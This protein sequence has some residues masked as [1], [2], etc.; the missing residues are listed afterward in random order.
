MKFSESI[1]VV[2]DDQS[3]DLVSL[4]KERGTVLLSGFQHQELPET[5]RSVEAETARSK[6]SGAPD[7]SSEPDDIFGL[8]TSPDTTEPIN[9]S[10]VE[11]ELNLDLSDDE[12]ELDLDG[13]I[14][15]EAGQP[16]RNEPLLFE[17]IRSMSEA[18]KIRTGFTIR[19]GVTHFQ[20]FTDRNYSD[21][22]KKELSTVVKEKV[23]GRL[24]AKADPDL[25]RS[26][27][28]ESSRLWV[29]TLDREPAAI[30]LFNRVDRLTGKRQIF[31]EEVYPD[32]IA[33][34]QFYLK[35]Y[36]PSRADGVTALIQCRKERTRVLF[37]YGKKWIHH[38]LIHEGTRHKSLAGTLFSK[39]LLQLDTS[40]IPGLDRILICDEPSGG[41]LEQS[42]TKQLPEVTIESFRIPS[43]ILTIPKD[44]S[45]G[46]RATT[47]IAVAFTVLQ[48][49]RESLGGLSMRPWYMED[50]QK[51]FKLEWHG[52]VVLIA[53]G[54][55]PL[56][57]NSVYQ[58]TTTETDQLQ[59]ELDRTAV[60]IEDLEE[61]VARVDEMEQS[62]LSY[63]QTLEE[64]Y[65]L[66]SGT[67]RWSRT[68][69]H[70]NRSVED[71]GGIWITNYRYP[72]EGLVLEGLALQ[73]DR[74]PQLARRFSRVTLIQVRQEQVR[75]RPIYR[76]TM[77]IADVFANPETLDPPDVQDISRFLEQTTGGTP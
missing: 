32:E 68:L 29:A 30:E 16:D 49:D 61:T 12:G 2:L 55:M 14:L 66:S 47:A 75:E 41:K 52:A 77:R 51:L 33:L 39:L 20:S 17:S 54:L 28:D 27:V 73:E 70:L 8:D 53:I 10:I 25:F 63:Q 37:M 11:E 9:S 19:S 15:E 57:F 35:C 44:Q 34:I 38:T 43:K 56:L 18:R 48:P 22:K 6:E 69:D 46:A 74:I 7:T 65:E 26:C 1:G 42:L 45:E 5:L 21:L 13:D 59:L 76:F 40:E 24:G 60:F 71:V 23:K 50:R 64:L 62:L 4:R 72:P 3:V 67:I 31:I 58:S 36:H